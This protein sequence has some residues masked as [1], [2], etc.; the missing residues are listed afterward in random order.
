MKIHGHKHKLTVATSNSSSSAESSICRSLAICFL[1]SAKVGSW[2]SSVEL[3]SDE[4][5]IGLRV[6]APRKNS[7]CVGARRK[8]ILRLSGFLGGLTMSA[9]LCMS[10]CSADKVMRGDLNDAGG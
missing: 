9:M 6:R 5:L 1:R 7:S 8:K 2:L 3:F 4:R 10:D